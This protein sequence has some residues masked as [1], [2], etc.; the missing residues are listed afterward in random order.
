MQLRAAES[1]KEV[2]QMG[3]C[4]E[5]KELGVDI[6]E[7]LRRLGGNEA[8][9]TKLLGSFVKMAGAYEVDPEF[10]ASDV[11]PVIEKTHAL[12]GTAG[13]LSLTPLYK[14]YTQIV[15]LLRAGQPEIA[16]DELKKIIPVQDAILACIQKHM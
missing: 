8:L 12:K 6:D 14:A 4:E 2:I 15:D 7:A 13:N 5:L 10:D 3:L 11:T 9:Y 1:K 16:R